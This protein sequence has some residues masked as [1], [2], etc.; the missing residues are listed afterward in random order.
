MTAAPTAYSRTFEPPAFGSTEVAR[1]AAKMPATAA[2]TE[3]IM[4]HAI[5]TLATLM[6]ARR[7]AS[8]LPPTA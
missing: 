8:A 6:P 2:M 4:K 7:V 1:E 5:R 3:Q